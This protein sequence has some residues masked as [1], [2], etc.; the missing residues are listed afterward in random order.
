MA[1]NPFADS[2]IVAGYEAWYQT[3]GCRVDH[4]E[5]ALLGRLLADFAGASAIL[6]VG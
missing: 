4:R 2:A 1:H 6:E 3:A 5:K